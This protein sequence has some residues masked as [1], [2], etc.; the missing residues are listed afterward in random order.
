MRRDYKYTVEDNGY[1]GWEEEG[2]KGEL[3]TGNN[4]VFRSSSSCRKEGVNTMKEG[5]GWID[6]I[7][8]I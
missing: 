5:H 1:L 4:Y 8:A 2:S 3:Q 7:V 6:G